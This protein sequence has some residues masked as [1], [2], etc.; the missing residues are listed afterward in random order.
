MITPPFSICARPAFTVKSGTAVSVALGTAVEG[1]ASLVGMEAIVKSKGL[2]VERR[3][4]RNN[5]VRQFQRREYWLGGRASGLIRKLR[6][7]SQDG[8]TPFAEHPAR[9]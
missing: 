8:I 1:P 7:M 5:I 6:A 9:C 4:E 2:L 3:E